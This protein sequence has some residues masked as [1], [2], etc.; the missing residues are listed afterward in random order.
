MIFAIVTKFYVFIITIVTFMVIVRIAVIS[1]PRQ[2]ESCAQDLL[3]AWV[4]R[5]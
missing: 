1:G 2:S 5:I 4:L 3:G